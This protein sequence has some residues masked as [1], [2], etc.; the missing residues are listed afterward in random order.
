MK[1]PLPES[2]RAFLR[3]LENTIWNRTK[4]GIGRTHSF[5]QNV[6]SEE[7]VDRVLGLIRGYSLPCVLGSGPYASLHIWVYDH[8]PLPSVPPEFLVAFEH[9]HIPATKDTTAYTWDQRWDWFSALTHTDENR[10]ICRFYKL[11]EPEPKS[12]YV[13]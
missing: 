3:S 2:D 11:P 7:Q 4:D 1:P 6:L 5:T 9:R 12:R 10:D 13:Y 8:S